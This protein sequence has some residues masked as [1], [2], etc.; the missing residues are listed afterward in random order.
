MSWKSVD[1]DGTKMWEQDG[2]RLESTD[3]IDAVETY[4]KNMRIQRETRNRVEADTPRDIEYQNNNETQN[5]ALSGGQLAF[6][7]IIVIAMIA[8]TYFR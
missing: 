4:E 7:A 6:L 2:T 5:D 1:V 3:Q 8:S